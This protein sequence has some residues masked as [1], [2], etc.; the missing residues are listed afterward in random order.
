MGELNPT[1]VKCF[2]EL[3]A[4]HLALRH[5]LNKLTLKGD[6]LEEKLARE[7]TLFENWRIA[8]MD[9]LGRIAE[10]FHNGDAEPHRAFVR[11][12]R[13]FE[14]V[15]EAP[16]YWQII[17][18]PNGYAGDAQMMSFIYRNQFEGKTPF[19]MLLHK[20]AVSTKAC[21]AVRN[22]KLFLTQ[23]ITKLNGGKVLSLAAGPAQEIRELLDVYTE[24]PYHFLALDHDMD[25]LKAYDISDREPRFK[26][27]LANAF[28]IISGNYM[29]AR[30]RRLMVNFCSPRKDFRGLR[31]A[32]SPLKYEM[33]YLKKES[34]DLIYSS[35]LYDYI[36]TFP[37]D[38][39]KGTVAL[40][41]NL[42][43]LLRPGGSLVVGNF[44]FGNPVD[45]KFVMEYVYHWF[46]FYRDE[47]DM[48]EFARAI[49]EEQIEDIQ[50]FK[51][52]LGINYFLK[53]TKKAA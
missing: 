51:E 48:L 29:A 16:F 21:Q 6:A 17:N 35:G 39:S 11:S 27:A 24:D 28:Q 44:T 42:F 14:A 18:K 38:D 8:L 25:T 20:H 5:K 30:P 45:L 9:P 31:F 4:G 1:F 3:E 19:G 22:R 33:S 43:E 10:S 2:K 47:Q 40:T 52:S 7:L 46:L 36:K 13:Y 37:L 50:V 26:Y 23:E 12:S 15:Q 32:L 49:P 34:F 53:I 41:R